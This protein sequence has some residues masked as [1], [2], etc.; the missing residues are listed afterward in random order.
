MSKKGPT[1]L[2]HIPNRREK[3]RK[4]ERKKIRAR[5]R[6]ESMGVYLYIRR[7]SG[8][9]VA[10]WNYALRYWYVFYGASRYIRGVAMVCRICSLCRG[11][12]LVLIRAPDKIA[13]CYQDSC[14]WVARATERTSP[15][16]S[17]PGVSSLFFIMQRSYHCQLT[18]IHEK[19]V[20]FGINFFIL[21]CSYLDLFYQIH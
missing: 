8:I 13:L 12:V 4:K 16:F 5:E 19:M 18:S 17:S 2:T 1:Y 3:E 14:L 7:S 9:Q 11:H 10:Q 15:I 21:S 20:N 6:A